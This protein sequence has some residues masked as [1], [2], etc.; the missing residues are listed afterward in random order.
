MA[1]II[2]PGTQ[3]HGKDCSDWCPLKDGTRTGDPIFCDLS[4]KCRQ[5]G[6]V[7]KWYKFRDEITG[8]ESFDYFCTGFYAKDEDKGVDEE[9]S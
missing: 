8:E 9:V 4:L 3:K 1:N 2:I 7:S 6:M 5:V